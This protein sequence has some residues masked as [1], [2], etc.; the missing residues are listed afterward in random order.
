MT[1]HLIAQLTMIEELSQ[2]VVPYAIW[3]PNAPLTKARD[4]KDIFKG[5]S[6]EDVRRCKRKFRKFKRRIKKEYPRFNVTNGMVRYRITCAA[7]EKV[8]QHKK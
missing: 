8:R 4:P 7:E 2:G 6:E 1:D 5:M 3:H